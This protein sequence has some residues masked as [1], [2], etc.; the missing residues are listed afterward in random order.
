M[1][2]VIETS[3]PE[4]TRQSARRIAGQVSSGTVIALSGE[5][6]AGKTVFAKG[7]CHA[8]G[9]GGNVSSP[10]FTLVNIYQ[11]GTLTINH[12]DCYRLNDP[13]EVEDLGP[14][15]L[16]YPAGITLVEWAEKVKSYLPATTVWIKIELLTAESRRIEIVDP[17]T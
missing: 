12:V 2:A 14:D 7:F 13:S 17:R 15:E 3:S 4:E 1:R 5:L 6:G 11:V 10:S 8:L 9:F 16:F